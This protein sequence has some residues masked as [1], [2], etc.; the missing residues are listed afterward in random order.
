MVVWAN[1]EGVAF[2]QVVAGSR[3]VAGDVKSDLNQVWNGMT[4]ADAIRKLAAPP[5]AS[6]RRSDR[7]GR[8]IATSSSISS[9]APRSTARR[10]LLEL[11][12]GS[13]RSIGTKRPSLASR[14][15]LARRRC[16]IGKTRCWQRRI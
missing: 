14:I 8:T 5:I 15:T 11:S 4:R 12:K 2:G 7:R 9:R 1:E 6:Q 13:S 3:V 10:F 16:Q